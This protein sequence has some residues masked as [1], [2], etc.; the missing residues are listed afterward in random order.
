MELKKSDRVFRVKTVKDR[1]IHH[2]KVVL[3]VNDI[4]SV[5]HSSSVMRQRSVERQSAAGQ[6]ISSKQESSFQE[7]HTGQNLDRQTGPGPGKIKSRQVDTGIGA[8][9]TETGQDASAGQTKYRE[10]LVDK[11][12]VASQE[13]KVSINSAAAI[14]SSPDVDSLQPYFDNM[15]SNNYCVQPDYSRQTSVNKNFPADQTNEFHDK[16]VKNT[17]ANKYRKYFKTGSREY[18]IKK[19]KLKARKY[20][21]EMQGKEVLSDKL[22]PRQQEKNTSGTDTE[23]VRKQRTLETDTRKNKNTR[24]HHARE[25][26]RKDTKAARNGNQDQNRK[27]RNAGREKSSRISF[28]GKRLAS[29]LTSQLGLEE[30]KDHLPKVVAEITKAKLSKVALSLLPALAPALFVIIFIMTFIMI[31]YNSPFAILLPS[32]DGRETVMDV[33]T[34]YQADFEERISYEKTQLGR[35]SEVEI[36]YSG[37]EGDGQPQNFADILMVYMMKYGCGNTAT[38]MNETSKSKLAQLFQ[39]MTSLQV[40]YRTEIREEPYEVIDQYGEVIIMMEE[41]E[42]EI[43]EI[44]ISLLNHREMADHFNFTDTDREVLNYLMSPEVLERLSGI[45][46]NSYGKTGP[47]SLTKDQQDNLALGNDIGSRAVRK[48]IEKLGIPYSQSYR[49][50]GNYYDCS[51]LTYYCYQEVGISLIYQGSNTAAAQAELLA[52]SGCQIAYEDIRPGDLI[53]YSFS[54]NGRYQDISHTAIY[55]GNGYVVDASSSKGYVIFRH[56]YSVG[57]IVMCGRPG[58]L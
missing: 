2:A 25:S 38:V 53:F 40:D 26:K 12:A 11:K 55:A 19:S 37:Y 27:A 29:Y 46:T 34:T 21:D 14:G 16:R 9:K 45:P 44:H 28:A 15:L 24:N 35:A 41:I 51:S 17:W 5:P 47:V 52:R 22:L 36:I 43:K 42:V 7:R 30:S 57:S 48:A 20:Q 58:N 8:G 33:I 3:K 39:H 10:R 1:T 49:D 4:S 54:K 13:G 50:S 31:I 6:Y 56:V 18:Q 23:S 32:I